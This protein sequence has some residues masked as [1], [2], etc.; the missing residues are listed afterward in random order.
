LD[1]FFPRYHGDLQLKVISLEPAMPGHSAVIHHESGHILLV[2]TDR[3]TVQPLSANVLQ[4]REVSSEWARF[5]AA[6][7]ASDGLGAPGIR[8]SKD[9]A[10]GGELVV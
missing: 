10:K 7:S 3:S 4:S 9:L 5:G 6:S 8:V 2:D 1:G